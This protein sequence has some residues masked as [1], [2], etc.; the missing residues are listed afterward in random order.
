MSDDIWSSHSPTLQEKRA[1][2]VEEALHRGGP[3]AELS[4]RQCLQQS[5]S[6]FL[7]FQSGAASLFREP[8]F[9]LKV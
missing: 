9:I 6:F 4:V 1:F 3:A 8:S 2:D 7:D 5:L